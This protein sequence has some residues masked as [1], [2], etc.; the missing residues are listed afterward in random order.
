MAGWFGLFVTGLNLLPIGQLDGGHVV[1][2]LVGRR[3]RWVA[4]AF[5]LALL[6]LGLLGWAGWF[7]WA[8]LVTFAGIDHPPTADR[9]TPL[10]P[11]RRGLAW[12]TLALFFV[13]LVP[14]PIMTIDGGIG[15]DP[16]DLI[17]ASYEPER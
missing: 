5:L 11:L 9:E 17:P 8:V 3:H 6:G 13:T 10:D 7:V 16:E 1:Y 15:A 4:R 2:S 12:A 14:V